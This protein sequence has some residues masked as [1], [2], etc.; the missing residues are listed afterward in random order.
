MKET[1]KKEDVEFLEVDIDKIS[2][3]WDFL[4]NEP[5]PYAVILSRVSL[6]EA[7][8]SL[9]GFPSGSAI[10]PF[11]GWVGDVWPPFVERRSVFRSGW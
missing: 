11:L 5:L 2:D 1:F 4:G 3:I 9:L 8:P 10:F 6:R 7:I